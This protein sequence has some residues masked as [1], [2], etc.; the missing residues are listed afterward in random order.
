MTT[1]PLKKH[2]ET[3]VVVFNDVHIPEHDRKAFNLLL[4]TIREVQPDIVICL[5]DFLDCYTISRFEKDPARK[6]RLNHEILMARIMLG[7]VADATNDCQ[8]IF[9][10]GNHEDR[11]RKYVWGRCPDL[12]CLP[13]LSW[14][15]LLHLSENGWEYI[16]Y[17]T[18]F[19]I[20]NLWYHHGNVIR[21]KS[22]YTARAL[23]DKVGGNAIC[24]HTHRLAH[25]HS[26]T[27]TDH[28]QAWENGCLCKLKA[29]Y[30][31]GIPDWQQG[32]SIVTYTKG[33]Q[34]F[35][36]DQLHIHKGKVWLGGAV[37]SG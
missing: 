36:V 24:G 5:G 31:I 15:A 4:A 3:T 21:Q 7:E 29:S 37:F 20:G 22:G 2:G 17:E 6:Y 33:G 14:D 19:K 10:E 32:F 35:T 9:H 12:Q 16:P 8:L 11:L 23:M 1:I 18:P 25:I 28:L 30:I 13:E 34:R 26:T 27:W